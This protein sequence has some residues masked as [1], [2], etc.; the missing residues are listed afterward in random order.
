MLGLAFFDYLLRE[1]DWK[2]LC[3]AYELKIFEN[4]QFISSSENSLS[5][6]FKLVSKVPVG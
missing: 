3:P 5:G 1:V 2:A 4:S 6:A